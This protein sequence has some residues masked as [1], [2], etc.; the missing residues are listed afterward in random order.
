MQSKFDSLKSSLHQILPLFS[1]I[2]G[3][4]IAGIVIAVIFA[5]GLCCVCC[6]CCIGAAICKTLKG[7]RSRSSSRGSKSSSGR[8]HYNKIDIIFLLRP[9]QIQRTRK[10]YPFNLSR[11]ILHSLSKP[12]LNSLSK[13]IHRSPSLTLALLLHTTLADSM[14]PTCSSLELLCTIFHI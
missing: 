12:I 2:N 14:F 8:W 5:M 13:S 4:L 11:P 10:I 7:G 3:G 6:Y 1:Q 9:V